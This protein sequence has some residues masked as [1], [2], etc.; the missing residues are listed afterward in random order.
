MKTR[1]LEVLATL[2]RAGA[3]NVAVAL[4]RGLDR[5]RFETAVVSLFDP[6]ADGLQGVLE[7]SGIQRWHLGKRK[8]FDPRMWA[9]LARVFRE[10]RP[11]VVHTHSYVLRYAFP[12]A[13]AARAGAMVHTVHNLAE[14]EVDA[15]GRW[16]N[17][18]AFWRGVTPVAV[19]A[20]VATSFRRVYGFDVADTIPNGIDLSRCRKREAGAAWRRE[21]GF[22]V[23]H[24]LAVSVARL[25]PQKDPLGLIEA[26]AHGLKHDV[27]CHLL[28]VGGG[29]LD[30]AARSLAV[31]RGLADRVHFLGVRGD[32]PEI[33]SA[34]DLFVLAS[35]W[36]GSPLAVMEAMIRAYADLFERLRRTE[37]DA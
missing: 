37:A 34:A 18:F 31:S 13:R 29:S 24:V 8:G 1:V 32:V 23:E 15:F 12:A 19:S 14:R 36:E 2:G 5:A 21:H 4:A 28:L 27:H 10:Y 25:E 30:G 33:L 17:R 11:D 16:V 9:R 7:E 26:F 35:R 6:S 22:A 3:E 20:R